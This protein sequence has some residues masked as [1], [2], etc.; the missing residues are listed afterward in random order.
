MTG[1]Q[2]L[3]G[4]TPVTGAPAGAAAGAPG[5]AAAGAPAGAA[6]GAVTGHLDRW[7]AACLALP[8]VSERLSHG[9]P[10][11]FVGGKRAF[12]MCY[13]DG[14]HGERFA[15]TWCAAPAGVL[16]E[17]LETEPDRF[18]RPP[19]VGTR[20]WIGVRLD[21]VAAEGE[22]EQIC[23]EAYLVV[24]PSRLAARVGGK[25]EPET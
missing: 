1:G 7:R 16:E 4:R 15:Q 18:F 5:G 14:H 2:A 25:P 17:L 19:Y 24:A 23:R 6:G 21:Q 3:G 22:V 12:V 9:A 11:F 10:T 20:G 13:P 8:E